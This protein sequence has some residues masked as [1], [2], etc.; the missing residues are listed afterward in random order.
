MSMK[1]VTGGRVEWPPP[2]REATEKYAPQVRLSTDG[3]SLVGY[4]AGE[5]FL[6][7]DPNDSDA[8]TNIVWNNMF[9]ATSTGDYDCQGLRLYQ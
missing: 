1:I 6:F 7:I 8:G 3:R 2:Y 5:P 4:V 9:R